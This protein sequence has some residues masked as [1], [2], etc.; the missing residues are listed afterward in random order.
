MEKSVY[1]RTL[2]L[3]DLDLIYQWMNDDELKE[4]SIGLN[5]RMSKEECSNWIQARKD[6][7]KQYN[8]YWAICLRKD[9]RLIGYASLNDVHYINRTAFMGGI[10]I[11][12]RGPETSFALYETMMFQLDFA[13]NQL[14]MH[15]VYESYM[16][17]H[18]SSRL[19]GAAMLYKLDG[20]FRQH[21]FKNGIYHDEVYGSL[22]EDEYRTYRS[23]GLYDIKFFSKRMA[24]A[25]RVNTH[26]R[27]DKYEL[28]KYELDNLDMDI[29]NT[30]ININKQTKN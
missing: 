26:G 25:K 19:I 15:R 11:G 4:L 3:E 12:D 27:L 18:E 21:L 16:A 14:N 9:N 24:E 28:D 23:M 10:I 2:E 5:R 7:N 17:D 13:F 30:N 1:F 20:I 8:F 6:H 22:L 29:E